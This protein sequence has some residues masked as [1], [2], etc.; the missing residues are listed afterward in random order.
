MQVDKRGDP[1]RKESD[2]TKELAT[3]QMQQIR[4]LTRVSDK[5]RHRTL[6]GMKEGPNPMFDLQFDLFRLVY[7]ACT[8]VRRV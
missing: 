2:R 6:F 5:V 1:T 8:F 4:A 3:S 7:C